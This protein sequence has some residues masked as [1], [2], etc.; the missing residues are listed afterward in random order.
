[1]EDK[2]ITLEQLREKM[3]AVDE[4]IIRAFRKRMKISSEIA[5]YK[6]ENGLLILDI[7]REKSK[8]DRIVKNEEDELSAFISKLYLVLADL[9]KEYQKMIFSRED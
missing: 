1:M 8:L 9:S 5:K 7:D 6:K 2:K 4:E 3:D